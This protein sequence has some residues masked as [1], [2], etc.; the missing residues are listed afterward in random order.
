MT[1]ASSFSPSGAISGPS[2][3]LAED[4]AVDEAPAALALGGV[5]RR[6]AMIDAIQTNHGDVH[7][8]SR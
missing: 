3:K 4:V 2:L 7:F 8:S 6:A 1:G 5:E